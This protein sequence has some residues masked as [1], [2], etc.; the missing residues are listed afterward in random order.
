MRC[1]M[2]GGCAV[3]FSDQSFVFLFLPAAL[4]LYF[5]FRSTPLALAIVL[6]TSLVFYYWSAGIQSLILVASILINFFG[7]LW[8]AARRDKLSLAVVIGADLALLIYFKYAFF[9]GSNLGLAHVH[10]LGDWLHA[11]VLPIGIS[12]FTFQGI[13]YAIDVWRGD[14]E[15]ERNII[16]FG[17][18]KSFFPQLIAGPI[19]RYRDVHHDFTQPKTSV[20]NFA[21]GATRF[22]HG[23]AK[24]VIVADS[25]ARVADAA[26]ALPF[27]NVVFIAAVIGAVAYA[28][29]IYF[30]FS[31]YSDMAIGLGLMFGVRILENFERP[32]ASKSITEFWRRWHISLSSWF[33]DY[34]Y[35]PLGGNRRG[36]THQ[37]GNLLIVFVAT[38]LWHGAAW[39]FL[40]WGLYHGVFI[41][42][43]RL[44]AGK[45]AKDLRLPAFRFLYCLPVVLVGWIIFRADTLGQAWV[46]VRA[47]GKPLGE[48]ALTL[49]PSLYVAFTP[50]ITAVFAVA[51][52]VFLLPGRYGL[53]TWLATPHA[54]APAFAARSA[55][56]L[57]CMGITLVLVLSQSYSPFLYFR[58]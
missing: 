43:E 49:P 56:L 6:I 11:I 58:F 20:E 53:G 50:G 1:P 12:F 46:F 16:T 13:S 34:L 17:A 37:Y 35:I 38:G 27:E 26:F 48:N 36:G 41:T 15:P 44:I 51:A 45:S 3:V 40:V 2:P 29:Q 5:A 23:L 30:D 57:A 47:L 39:T 10:P 8:I 25:V 32:Y 54:A 42:G 52:L 21:S 9:L 19:V 33:R 31:G 24:K 22:M 4:V 14:V 18:Y 55:Y 28:L 7:G